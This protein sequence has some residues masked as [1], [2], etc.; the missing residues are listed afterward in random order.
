M[1]A[2]THRIRSGVG[3][4]KGGRGCE[5]RITFPAA[6]MQNPLRLLDAQTWGEALTAIITDMRAVQS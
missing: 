5:A 6:S 3:N 2:V 1:S 4:Y